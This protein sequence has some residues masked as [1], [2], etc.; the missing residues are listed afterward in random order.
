M[1]P[2]VA[3][4]SSCPGI[5]ATEAANGFLENVP[6]PRHNAC[7]VCSA[8]ERLAFVPFA[9]TVEDILGIQE[10]RVVGSDNTM[11][12]GS[13]TLA[14]RCNS[15]RWI[16]HLVFVRSVWSHERGIASSGHR[17]PSAGRWYSARRAG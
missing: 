5:T 3:A 16:G 8:E 10:E 2:Q 17:S 14:G 6:V 7:F 13:R 11:H 12:Y 9:G 4:A 15:A 1:V